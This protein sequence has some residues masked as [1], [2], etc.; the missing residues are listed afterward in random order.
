[1]DFHN[2]MAP[3]YVHHDLLVEIGKVEMA[4]DYLNGHDMARQEQL[5]T[6][7]ESKMNHLRDELMRLAV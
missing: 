3:V 1:M 7:L 4:M 5:L 6:R 2:E